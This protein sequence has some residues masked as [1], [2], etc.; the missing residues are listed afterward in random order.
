MISLPARL[1]GATFAALAIAALSPALLAQGQLGREIAFVRA[2]AKDM[3]FIELAKSEADRLASEFRGA[4]DQD[5][6][7]QLAVEVAYY[8]AR[9]RNDRNQQRALFKETVEKSKELI[10]RSSD[11]DVKLQAMST[12]ANASQDFGQF[13]IQELDIA[14]TESPERVA[15]LQEEAISVLKAGK[16]AC[17]GVRTALESQR[18]D[19]QKEVEFYLM[20]MKQAVLTREQAK[21][22]KENRNVLVDRAIEELE[23]MVLEAG[24]ESALGLRGL[25]EIAQCYEV[26]GEIR[27]AITWYTDTIEQITTSLQEAQDGN[28]RLSGEMQG[29]LFG[30][31]QEVYV[32]AGETM[33]REGA[34]GTAE[35]FANFRKHIEKFGEEGVELFDVVSDS[36]GH[37]MLLAESRWKAESGDPA[38]VQ[39]A[40][41]MTQRINDKHPA[42]YVGVKAK[43]VLA[44]I[45]DLQKSLVSGSLLFEVGK[46]DLQKKEYESAIQNLRAAIASMT[47]EEKQQLG[48]EAHLML[49]NAY[50]RTDRQLEAIIAL[51][52]GVKQFGDKADPVSNDAGDSIDRAVSAHKRQTQDD[53]FFRTFWDNAINEAAKVNTGGADKV[54]YKEGTKLFQDKQWADAAAQFSKVTKDYVYYESA[55]VRV[56]RAHASAGDFAKAREALATY[57]KYVDENELHARDTGKQQVREAALA[58]AA[59]TDVQIA[60]Y[61]ARGNEE[62]GL[63]RDLSKYGAAVDAV[64]TFLSNYAEE[65]EIYVPQV[66]AFLGRLHVDTGALDKAEQ[67]YT[68]LKA[69]DSS[70]AARMATE[71]FQEYQNQVKGLVA[72]LDKG[73]AEGKTDAQLASQVQEIEAARRKLTALGTDYINSSPKPQLAILVNTML[74]WQELGEWQRVDE[75]AKK[76]L[77]LYGDVT[78][79]SSQRVVDQLVRPMVGEAL[80]QQ[81]RFQEAYDML[82]AAEKANPA[83]WEIKRQLARALGGWFEFS[84]TGAPVREPGLDRP[85][86]AYMKYYGDPEAS[87][88][89]WATR[90]EVAKFSLEW[91]RFMWEA[92]WF[93]K[94]AGRK[95]SKYEDVADKF[96]RIARSTNDFATLLTYGAEGKKIHTYFMSNR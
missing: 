48:M 52:E 78:D 81:R 14:R 84:N 20:W 29:F 31:M 18:E 63:D 58:A 71:I 62:F 79:E 35:L 73:I 54:A 2:L 60:Y 5:K 72:E 10:D 64:N 59:Y 13:L 86:E 28:L 83:Q 11:A 66:L 17:K 7:A 33:A 57:R 26:K 80:L 76:T 8:G 40:L 82:V 61:E 85:V 1:R 68:Q 89:I 65:G 53:P 36:Y 91:Y 96:F 67:A 74:A 37:L 45:L 19:P 94:Q 34:D 87:Y 50:R 4:G 25:F 75:V 15:E 70:R 27:E 77:E 6:I 44:D 92:Y 42:D 56:A 39:E 93:A 9:A 12:L 21:A 41:A 24:E 90:P 55:A 16:D 49:G 51:V 3:R 22:D 30:M 88:R 69:K 32:R 23:E 47:A 38:K 46:G 43:A 95:D